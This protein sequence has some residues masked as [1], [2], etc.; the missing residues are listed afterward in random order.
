MGDVARDVDKALKDFKKL[1]AG[2]KRYVKQAPKIS[3]QAIKARNS[4]DQTY[5]DAMTNIETKVFLQDK[6][7]KG[8][9]KA[10][11]DA[12]DKAEDAQMDFKGAIPGSNVQKK[13]ERDI[14]LALGEY[15]RNR[16]ACRAAMKELENN[17]T[18]AKDLAKRHKA[19]AAAK[20][21]KAGAKAG[22]AG[23]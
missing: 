10:A 18:H 6:H 11:E 14:K 7:L 16:E 21:A 8:H 9:L 13:A 19:G 15:A 4:G 12:L 3:A 20:G 1:D 17:F 23:G 2:A 22:A 5:A